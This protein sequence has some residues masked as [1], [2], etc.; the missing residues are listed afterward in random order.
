VYG[1]AILPVPTQL[2]LRTNSFIIPGGHAMK[3]FRSILL[4]PVLL[5][6][7]AAATQAQTPTPPAKAL[8][9]I[10]DFEYSTTV[11]G[12]QSAGVISIFKQ[13]DALKGKI[14]TD[15]MGEIPITAVKIEGNKVALTAVLPDGELTINLTFEDDNKFAGNWS[16]GAEGG[17]ISGKRKTT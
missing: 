3:R 12:Q 2:I 17:A 10:G 15:M 9:A 7:S 14:M 6:L 1:L 8:N 4:A 13:E 5:A 11:Q 16:L